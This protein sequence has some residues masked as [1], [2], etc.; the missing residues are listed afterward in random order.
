MVA[1]LEKH[2]GHESFSFEIKRNKT[3]IVGLE[4][5]EGGYRMFPSELSESNYNFYGCNN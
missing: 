3:G 1:D 5:R 2:G 4:N